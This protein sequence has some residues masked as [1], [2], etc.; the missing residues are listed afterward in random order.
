MIKELGIRRRLVI[1]LKGL[2]STLRR[3]ALWRASACGK[4]GYLGFGYMENHLPRLDQG[5]R[6]MTS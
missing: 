1:R 2:S 5:V 6:M 4:L 3:R